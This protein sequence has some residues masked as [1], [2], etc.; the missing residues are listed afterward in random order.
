MALLNAWAREPSRFL[1]S[2][3][4]RPPAAGSWPQAVWPDFV[5]I[6]ATGLAAGLAPLG[7]GS[8]DDDA[9][10]AFAAAKASGKPQSVL[11]L[12][13]PE[14]AACIR[15][16]DAKL[17]VVAALAF[18]DAASGFRF[19]ASRAGFKVHAR[20]QGLRKTTCGLL[21]L[22][23]DDRCPDRTHSLGTYS[24]AELSAAAEFAPRMLKQGLPSCLRPASEASERMSPLEVSATPPACV[25][26]CSAALSPAGAAAHLPVRFRARRRPTL[27]QVFRDVSHQEPTVHGCC[28]A[29]N[30]GQSPSHRRGH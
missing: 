2:P 24:L 13:H 19:L 8:D 6:L 18:A 28:P 4:S 1:K 3:P 9:V 16:C 29:P 10:A 12:A 15:L 30:L 23:F 25:R 22:T 11:D 14:C 17:L 5:Q 26:A 7:E 21:I 20:H 27:A